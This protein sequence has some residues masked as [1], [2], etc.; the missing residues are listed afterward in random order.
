MTGDAG[1]LVL[2]SGG[3]D[4]ATCLAWALDRFETVETVGFDYGQRHR[5]ELECRD[6]FRAR[7]VE[8]NPAWAARLGPDH[9]LDLSVLGQVSET[10]LTRDA[11]IALR[12]DGLPNTFVPGRNLLFFTL[13]AALASRRELRH[14]VG[15]MCETD[16]SG[17]PDCRDDTLKSLQVTLNLGIGSRSVVHTPLMWLDKAQTWGLAKIL[18]GEKLVDLIRTGTHTCYRGD[19]DRLQDW[20]Y[21]CGT[22]PACELRMK[23]WQ[24]HRS[25]LDE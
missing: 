8:L 4:S 16:Y 11:E 23:G 14:L 1:A 3:Q 25:S 17:Y 2:F 24:E 20:G 7:I 18:G 6:D 22:C 15:G 12:A 13:A 10:A 19:H 9:K 5:V 21:G